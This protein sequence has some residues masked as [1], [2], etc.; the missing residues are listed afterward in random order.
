MHVVDSAKRIVNL[1]P[2]VTDRFVELNLGCAGKTS[3]NRLVNL[4]NEIF[5][6][7]IE[8]AIQHPDFEFD[9]SRY[10]ELASLPA[11]NLRRSLEVLGDEIEI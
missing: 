11:A 4:V 2:C 10:Y 1:L 9:L 7:K 8:T 5:D 6:S 3:V